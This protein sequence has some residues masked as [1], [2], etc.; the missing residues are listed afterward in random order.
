MS[1]LKQERAIYDSWK[2]NNG[3]MKT[4]KKELALIKKVMFCLSNED[5]NKTTKLD[6]IEGL[7][8]NGGA[9]RCKHC[10]HVNYLFHM[11]WAG[12][13]CGHCSNMIDKKGRVYED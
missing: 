4:E 9:V 5:W 7:I 3:H 10:K 13:T 1:T 12:I 11:N 8:M 6:S 2:N